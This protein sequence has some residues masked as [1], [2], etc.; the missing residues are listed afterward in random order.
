MNKTLIGT[1]TDLIC[2]DC[3]VKNGFWILNRLSGSSEDIDSVRPMEQTS[4]IYPGI[5]LSRG[6]NIDG[7][8]PRPRANTNI[9]GSAISGLTLSNHV[10]CLPTGLLPSTLNS[11][12]LKM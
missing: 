2:V 4:G 3:A 9:S 10:R 1:V 7:D 6:G 11:I 8:E 5:H 12:H